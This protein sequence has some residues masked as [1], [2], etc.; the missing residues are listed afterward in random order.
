MRALR[1]F[2]VLFALFLTA[3][4]MADAQAEPL[5]IG[6]TLPGEIAWSPDGAHLL[7]AASDVTR[8]YRAGEWDAPLRTFPA[9][10]RAKWV[11]IRV[12]ELDGQRYEVRTGRAVETP[13]TV[14][15]NP[16]QPV[17]NRLDYPSQ[18]YTVAKTSDITLELTDVQNPDAPVIELPV[19]NN[20]TV[21]L[22]IFSPDSNKLA[23]LYQDWSDTRQR[24]QLWDVISQQRLFEVRA[25]SGSKFYEV[26]FSEDNHSLLA[27]ETIDGDYGPYGTIPTNEFINIWDTATGEL[28]YRVNG[29]F[30]LPEFG[31]DGWLAYVL[32][33]NFSGAE[34][35]VWNGTELIHT[36]FFSTNDSYFTQDGEMLFAVGFGY[37]EV[38]VFRVEFERR[39]VE[40]IGATLTP[41]EQIAFSDDGRIL[42]TKQYYD[43]P[44]FTLWHTEP[45]TLVTSF[46]ADQPLSGV[47]F[48][49]NN[50]LFALERK[51]FWDASTGEKVREFDTPV[52]IAPDWSWISYWNGG[53]LVFHG[54][55]D[56]AEV[57]QALIALDLG[58]AT[59][60]DPLERWAFFWADST[61]TAYSLSDGEQSFTLPNVRRGEIIFATDGSYIAVPDSTDPYSY[62]W[63]L[64]KIA[65]MTIDPVGS[66]VTSFISPD[67]KFTARYEPEY[68]Q[69]SNVTWRPVGTEEVVGAWIAN[70]GDIQRIS[71]HPIENWL[72]VE[73]TRQRR[74]SPEFQE[75][76]QP[77]EVY[78][79]DTEQTN[80]QSQTA[81]VKLMY[82]NEPGG[83]LSS[84][85]SPAGRFLV[86]SCSA[87]C[88]KIIDLHDLPESGSLMQ[89]VSK[90]FGASALAYDE[91]ESM[92]FVKDGQKDEASLHVWDTEQEPLIFPATGDAIALNAD[93]TLAATVTA[94]GIALWDVDAVRAGDLTPLAVYPVT[95]LA[96]TQ[97]TF[98]AADRLIALEPSGVTV[99]APP[100]SSTTP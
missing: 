66:R 54:L 68:Y 1:L 92:V 97:L 100:S 36:G 3:F 5:R 37:N 70:F 59:V 71:Y 29:T 17:Y 44:K 18:R 7:V 80:T 24:L 42:L 48:S 10:L 25:T 75:L 76:R 30:S 91:G 58:M 31:A 88:V 28:T 84:R 72:A 47:Q 94:D 34:L 81:V 15:Q 69:A 60:T 57:R 87:N 89:P 4:S 51:T 20:G 6:G 8:L 46:E 2:L 86:L 19:N 32:N 12:V 11:N 85:F 56:G 90:T 22:T 41:S 61:L 96:P 73:V 62:P 64:H 52:Q 77:T 49:P 99:Y 14:P 9:A 79:I 83:S 26:R 74:W 55:S 13:E 67:G 38:A 39:T 53:E 78:L 33:P 45:M 16:A 21:L 35:A 95:G 50:S 27:F 43:S 82:I 65:D 98:D 93:G 40:Q 23:I 63:R